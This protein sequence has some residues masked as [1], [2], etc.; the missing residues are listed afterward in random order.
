VRPN[1]GGPMTVKVQI[2]KL[3]KP[4]RRTDDDAGSN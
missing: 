1:H 4:H 2:K 3:V